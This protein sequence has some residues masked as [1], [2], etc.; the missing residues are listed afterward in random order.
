MASENS[1]GGSSPLSVSVWMR[2]NVAAKDALSAVQAISSGQS[3]VVRIR[4]TASA[5]VQA[6]QGL[7]TDGAD[8]HIVSAAVYVRGR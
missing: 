1:T 8:A 2:G 5:V 6:I 3:A 7:K 4:G